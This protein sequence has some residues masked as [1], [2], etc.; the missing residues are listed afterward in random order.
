LAQVET[1]VARQAIEQLYA[2]LEATSLTHRDAFTLLR[3]QARQ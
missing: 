1:S 2:L 3:G